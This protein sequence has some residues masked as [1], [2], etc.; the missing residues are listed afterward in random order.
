MLIRLS[1]TTTTPSE[2]DQRIAKGN[3]CGAR[4][5]TANPWFIAVFAA[6]V[7]ASD[8]MTTV[9]PIPQQISGAAFAAIEQPSPFAGGVAI[10]RL[11]DFAHPK[12]DASLLPAQYCFV[13]PGEAVCLPS[14]AKGWMF[15]D[16]AASIKGRQ[17][18]LETPAI[19]SGPVMLAAPPSEIHMRESSP[20]LAWRMCHNRM[21][22]RVVSGVTRNI[23]LVNIGQTDIASRICDKERGDQHLVPVGFNR[24]SM[25]NKKAPKVS[26]RRNYQICI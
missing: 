12:A 3:R 23:P 15:K 22:S 25:Q 7:M 13:G 20:K 26:C 1:P 10:G 17:R 5:L 24:I 14:I 16:A 11:P 19:I 6:L 2:D 18:G 21:I 8:L 4:R 9:R